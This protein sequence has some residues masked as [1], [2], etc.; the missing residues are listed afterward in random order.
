MATQ[1]RGQAGRPGEYEA[2]WVV[3]G[4][5]RS[6]LLFLPLRL[7]RKKD[8]VPREPIDVR[9]RAQG[10]TRSGVTVVEHER[11]SKGGDEEE[12][13]LRTCFNFG[14]STCGAGGAG[15]FQVEVGIH[16]SATSIGPSLIQPT[17]TLTF[18]NPSF[19]SLSSSSNLLLTLVSREHRRAP[20]LSRSYHTSRRW[21]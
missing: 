19:P 4:S 9:T 14:V 17:F 10:S 13:C 12:T 16:S 5:V 2:C 1:P 21:E 20:A 11:A 6:R 7:E 15:R 3:A 8:E 18:H